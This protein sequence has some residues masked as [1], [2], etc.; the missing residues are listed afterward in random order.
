[1]GG[2][3]LRV[4]QHDEGVQILPGQIVEFSRQF[5]CVMDVADNQLDAGRGRGRTELGDR[6]G[7]T[8][9]VIDRPDP[10]DA[11]IEK[12]EAFHLPIKTSDKRNS[13][14]IVGGEHPRTGVRHHGVDNRGGTHNGPCDPGGLLANGQHCAGLGLK[15]FPDLPAE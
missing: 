4:H 12:P 3:H 9:R 7:E 15:S 6:M 11:W 10:F 13:A 14:N 8:R 2:V 5:V 1:M